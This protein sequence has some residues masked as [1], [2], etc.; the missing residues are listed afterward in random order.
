MSSFELFRAKSLR[1]VAPKRPGGRI[2]DTVV[3]FRP[4]GQP[5]GPRFGGIRGPPAPPPEAPRGL[6]EATGALPV[7]LFTSFGTEQLDRE[8]QEALFKFNLTLF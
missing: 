8:R 6:P 7:A 4:A 5:K 2:L 3:V 1:K